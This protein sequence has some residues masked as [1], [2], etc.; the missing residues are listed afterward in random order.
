[1]I[2][3][4]ALLLR[5][6]LLVD[7]SFRVTSLGQRVA[8]ATVFVSTVITTKRF[9]QWRTTATPVGAI[10]NAIAN[11]ATYARLAVT[12]MLLLLLL[13]L[14]MMLDGRVLAEVAMMVRRTEQHQPDT[15]TAPGVRL[16]VGEPTEGHVGQEVAE[17]GGVQVA[18]I[19]QRIAERRDGFL[20]Q[21]RFGRTVRHQHRQRLERI[22]QRQL[23]GE[24][25]H[26][27]RVLPGVHLRGEEQGVP[28]K[29]VLGRPLERFANVSVEQI[30]AE[31]V[32]NLQLRKACLG[33]CSAVHQ[34]RSI[35]RV[36]LEERIVCRIRGLTITFSVLACVGFTHI[37]ALC[38][39]QREGRVTPANVGRPDSAAKELRFTP[40]ASDDEWRLLIELPRDL[41]SARAPLYGGPCRSCSSQ[42]SM[43]DFLCVTP[44][45]SGPGYAWNSFL[46][47]SP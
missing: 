5:L 3:L 47:A 38:G 14:K 18:P 36:L 21:L 45:T 16:D 24:L 25:H 37:H 4:M 13:L 35:L 32:G 6:L 46:L 28:P 39:R 33:C 23:V 12:Q 44:F 15:G 19:V 9:R 7:R 30:V 20:D 8:H 42:N 1:M 2:R 40:A 22:V 41:I 43:T 29:I 17:V 34:Q 26:H 31:L 11:N 10:G 27:V